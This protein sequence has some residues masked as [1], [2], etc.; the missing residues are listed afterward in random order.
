MTTLIKIKTT[1]TK[2]NDLLRNNSRLI[3][4]S[5]TQQETY[6]LL[7]V[8]PNPLLPSSSLEK[9]RSL[10]S[11]FRILVPSPPCFSPTPCRPLL[12]PRP[13]FPSLDHPSTPTPL[14]PPPTFWS[15]SKHSG[16]RRGRCGGE[17]D[18]RVTHKNRQRDIRHSTR[19]WTG[20]SGNMSITEGVTDRCPH[21]PPIPPLVNRLFL[22]GSPV[23]EVV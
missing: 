20:L 9:L 4:L 16:T 17:S 21:V 22:P 1:L 8:N 10:R 11:L 19:L 18:V 2:K 5:V 7:S 13:S 15:E 23:S 3:R 6:H 14:A 12:L